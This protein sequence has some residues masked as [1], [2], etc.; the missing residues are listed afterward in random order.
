MWITTLLFVFMGCTEDPIILPSYTPRVLPDLCADT[1]KEIK[2]LWKF[3]LR[4]DT[5]RTIVGDIVSVDKDVVIYTDEN[6]YR[7]DGKT[8]Q[9][10]WLWSIPDLEAKAGADYSMFRK[11]NLFLINGRTI[12]YCLDVNSGKLVRQTDKNPNNRIGHPRFTL[13]GNSMYQ[14]FVNR[15]NTYT[16]SVKYLQRADI[17]TCKWEDIFLLRKKDHDD[18]DYGLAEPPALFLKNTGDSVLM[19]KYRSF[20]ASQTWTRLFFYAYNINQRKVEWRIDS[21]DYDG[22]IHPAIVEKDRVFVE[23]WGSIYCIDA[24]TGVIIWTRYCNGR[25]P[26]GSNLVSYKDRLAAVTLDGRFVCINKTT[27]EFIYNYKDDYNGR[28]DIA[29]PQNAEVLN[30]VMYVCG[31]G[32]LYGIDLDT[33][34]IIGKYETPNRCKKSDAIFG[35]GNLVVNE[36][37]NCIYLDD[38]YF[39]MCFKAFK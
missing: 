27:G 20:K 16:D 31:G 19:F 10:K 25:F 28:F 6:V 34:N 15:E 8:G 18:Y 37:Q 38:E 9:S 2:P 11:D 23:G 30:G 29:S 12:N 26:G 33:G 14:E 24:N 36:Q 35:Y 3:P 1:T 7:I 32:F 22:S 39:L 21:L 5:G 4:L 17:N 13:I